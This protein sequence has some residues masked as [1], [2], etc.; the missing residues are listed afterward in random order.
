M[1]KKD[2]NCETRK[3]IVEKGEQRK[4]KNGDR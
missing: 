3:K 4:K 2:R 1:E